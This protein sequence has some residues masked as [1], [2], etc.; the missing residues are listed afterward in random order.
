MHFSGALLSLCISFLALTTPS[1]NANNLNSD[2][3][4]SS[5]EP[6][7]NSVSAAKEKLNS[8]LADGSIR[9]SGSA[10]NLL[11]PKVQCTGYKGKVCVKQCA[12]TI[13]GKIECNN[14]NAQD[15]GSIIPY[16]KILKGE[17]VDQ[18]FG[19]SHPSVTQIC[20]KMCGCE[21]NGKFQLGGR[22]GEKARLMADE[23]A[24]ADLL[25]KVAKVGG[26]T[27]SKP[28][29][30]VNPAGLLDL[31]PPRATDVVP[32]RQA[33]DAIHLSADQKN[34]TPRKAGL[35][36][37]KLDVRPKVPNPQLRD[38]VLPFS[39][40]GIPQRYL[41]VYEVLSRDPTIDWSDSPKSIDAFQPKDAGHILP[42]DLPVTKPRGFPN[43]QYGRSRKVAPASQGSPAQ[44]SPT[45]HPLADEA[46]SSTAVPK[47]YRRSNSISMNVRPD[48]YESLP[49]ASPEASAPALR[50]F[51][52]YTGRVSPIICVGSKRLRCEQG[53]YCAADGNVACDRRT[54]VEKKEVPYM[55]IKWGQHPETTVEEARLTLMSTCLS[56]CGCEMDG[57][58]RVAG[59]TK[60]EWMEIRKQDAMKKKKPGDEKRKPETNGNPVGSLEMQE[61]LERPPALPPPSTTPPTAPRHAQAEA[62]DPSL[63]RRSRD[64]TPARSTTTVQGPSF[65][66]RD[67]SSI[68]SISSPPSSRFPLLGSAKANSTS[69]ALTP[70]LGKRADKKQIA[71]NTQIV[72]K[73]YMKDICEQHC[74]C[75]LAGQILCDQKQSFVDPGAPANWVNAQRQV[76]EE[77]REDCLPFCK[78]GKVSNADQLPNIVSPPSKKGRRV[79]RPKIIPRGEKRKPAVDVIS[80]QRICEGSSKIVCENNC[81][82]NDGGEFRCDT[83]TARFRPNQ[84][85]GTFI[86][87]TAQLREDYRQR[88]GPSCKCEKVSHVQDA[89]PAD[90]ASS[91]TKDSKFFQTGPG[92]VANIPSKKAL[93]GPAASYRWSVAHNLAKRA[94]SPSRP[95]SPDSSLRKP[96][97]SRR[98]PVRKELCEAR[99]YCTASG[100]VKCDT[101]YLEHFYHLLEYA[102]MA[103]LSQEKLDEKIKQQKTEAAEFCIPACKCPQ[104]PSRS[105]SAPSL[106][107]RKSH[108]ADNPHIWHPLGDTPS[109]SSSVS[110]L[111]RRGRP[112]FG[113]APYEAQLNKPVCETQEIHYC[114][115]VCR[116]VEDAKDSHI[117]V[118]CDVTYLLQSFTPKNTVSNWLGKHNSGLI[119]R[120]SRG[121]RCE[122]GS[123]A[124]IPLV[125]PS[126]A[127]SVKGHSAPVSNTNIIP[128]SHSSREASSSDPVS[129]LHRRGR[130]IPK[131]DL[132]RPVC[133]G[134]SNDYCQLVCE[135]TPADLIKC[136]IRQIS[137]PTTSQTTLNLIFQHNLRLRDYC[138]TGCKCEERPRFPDP[139]HPTVSNPTSNVARIAAARDPSTVSS[140]NGVSSLHR[141]GRPLPDLNDIDPSLQPTCW[142]PD[143][144]YCAARCACTQAGTVKCDMRHGLSSG[145]IPSEVTYDLI[146]R[147]NHNIL[148]HCVPH[149]TC[150]ESSLQLVQS[151]KAPSAEM[152][153]I[154]HH[155]SSSH[156][157][158]NRSPRSDSPPSLHRRTQKRKK[159]DE[160]KLADTATSKFRPIKPPP[161]KPGSASLICTGPQKDL[162]DARCVC[163]TAGRVQC[164]QPADSRL[165]KHGVAHSM[166][167][168]LGGNAA[169]FLTEIIA[170]NA[171]HLTAYCSAGCHCKKP[172]EPPSPPR[173]KKLTRYDTLLEQYT[174]PYQPLADA[175]WRPH[176]RSLDK[177]KATDQP[178]HKRAKNKP[179]I[180]ATSPSPPS[181]SAPQTPYQPSHPH[182][183]QRPATCSGS[184]KSYCL[185]HCYCSL[186]GTLHCD[187]QNPATDPL[188]K[189][190]VKSFGP[191]TRRAYYTAHIDRITGICAP[192]C[193]CEDVAPPGLEENPKPKRKG[194]EL[195]PLH[196]GAPQRKRPA[197]KPQPRSLK[198]QHH[199]LHRRSSTG[200]TSNRIPKDT[201]A[202]GSGSGS[203]SASPSAF[204]SASAPPTPLAN[205]PSPPP[206]PARDF[207]RP[208]LCAGR[209][210]NFC[211]PR[212]WCTVSGDVR[213][214]ASNLWPNA[215]QLSK[216]H[217]DRTLAG[218]CSVSCLCVD[219]KVT[220][221]TA[222]DSRPGMG[223][224]RRR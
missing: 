93:S 154:S 143:E 1:A 180:P 222:G 30:E 190:L 109:S 223:V 19:S 39:L 200:S 205:H 20:S 155:S 217:K 33:S 182:P 43:N 174:L 126:T 136:Q 17:D 161:P 122:K 218:L 81:Y 8:L 207:R 124:T 14:D 177:R 137:L 66:Q 98:D 208:I 21:V 55:S 211:E 103:N 121:C 134:Y 129:S 62:P 92:E 90:E 41:D 156:D 59:K 31:Q 2:T 178:L 15:I 201:A 146:P 167:A 163:N 145:H 203:A 94:R 113:A 16:S 118:K 184:N 95:L 171:D 179:P 29:S 61:K 52:Q 173:A 101:E 26:R 142:G 78:C 37:K 162:C 160:D 166:E 183:F 165:A 139:S 71:D 215:R 7:G 120:C 22:P 219:E 99:C 49:E 158:P 65:L 47:L 45:R 105:A 152:P 128:G 50:P 153:G 28:H 112:R 117:K 147:E 104:V 18:Q 123:P 57:I 60:E 192:N 32:A 53:C 64:A 114:S 77:F 89:A 193:K 6:R 186:A 3:Q 38:P 106:L 35:F 224:L 151:A 70:S 24:N 110:I 133:E 5:I 199:P 102:R 141:R 127:S 188:I 75:N 13:D 85:L 80:F 73:S 76:M 115:T 150:K 149:C 172:A 40:D 67:Q 185:P 44:Q 125:Q 86:A 108:Q 11:I 148:R 42:S 197:P 214:D 138:S 56:T 12:C 96:I 194:S 74:R 68:N 72:C 210:K 36:R 169:Q 140:S 176:Q 116:C 206:S 220:K 168:Q 4:Q 63:V 88:C 87:T 82:C 187:A 209:L 157:L 54:D 212:C 132:A 79:K 144:R 84:S 27:G 58:T 131:P 51:G 46:S 191:S 97:C 175:H 9:S 213:C 135:C 111:H 204:A 91:S 100:E 195:A 83:V 130:P 34:S 170:K 159:M 119:Q 221:K 216:E 202:S 23:K 107:S 69:T 196:P 164:F 25:D 10:K 181:S 189:E 198:P 48:G